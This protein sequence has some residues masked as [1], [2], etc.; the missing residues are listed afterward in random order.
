[1]PMNQAA[2][3]PNQPIA[4]VIGFDD[5]FGTPLVE[6]LVRK[7]I[8]VYIATNN[9]SASLPSSADPIS[10]NHVVKDSSFLSS[11]AYCIDISATSK[12]GE[13]LNQKQLSKL[14]SQLSPTTRYAACFQ[15]PIIQHSPDD[16]QPQQTYAFEQ[17]LTQLVTELTRQGSLNGRVVYLQHLYG[18]HISSSSTTPISNLFS[19]LD[20][21]AIGLADPSTQ[22]LYPL[23][24]VDAAELVA[25]SLFLK[26]AKHQVLLAR[27]ADNTSLVNLGLKTKSLLEKELHITCDTIEY[28]SQVFKP[29]LTFDETIIPKK[30]TSF[31]KGL[32]T[33]IS[34]L[35]LPS[36]GTQSKPSQPSKLQPPTPPD[37]YA[38]QP[39]HLEKPTAPKKPQ[40]NLPSIPKPPLSP[41][42][43]RRSII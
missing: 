25:R 22:T 27:G 2:A 40:L 6:N 33:T 14:L 28:N 12:E 17:T 30:P 15:T 19:R 29:T 41:K 4:L 32:S 39:H 11:L 21:H 35:P 38:S 34:S 13:A 20:Q 8:R 10:F 7:K 1:M 31:E 24:T 5:F 43:N 37:D 36:Q 16:Q 9:Q 18:P 23:Y 26:S 42:K 3:L